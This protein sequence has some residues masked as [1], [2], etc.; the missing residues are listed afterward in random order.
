MSRSHEIRIF[1]PFNMQ[2]GSNVKMHT[3]IQEVVNYAE[4]R[5]SA[6]LPAVAKAASDKTVKW[7]QGLLKDEL[8]SIFPYC[9]NTPLI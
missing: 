2:H 8:V 4:S 3:Y 6:A 7:M 1:S 5:W 9:C